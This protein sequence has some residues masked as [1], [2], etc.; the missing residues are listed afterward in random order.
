MEEKQRLLKVF[1]K[2]QTFMRTPKYIES[3]I[4]V[5]ERRSQHNTS[6]E[7]T[8]DLKSSVVFG[9]PFLSIEVK[10]CDSRLFS[11]KLLTKLDETKMLL[12][13][14]SSGKA[15]RNNFD[16]IPLVD[17]QVT[18]PHIHFYD[19]FGRFM[20]KKTAEILADENKARDIKYGF[21]IFCK[22]GN[23]FGEFSTVPPQIQVGEEASLPFEIPEY[24]PCVGV[25]F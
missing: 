5:K 2:L 15:H 10:Q 21:P 6:L 20:A 13:Y 18:T 17:Q 14:D 23:I 9:E 3:P 25:K 22:E 24:D 7:Y 4:V 8:N 16:D 12:R 11:A 19:D 1:D